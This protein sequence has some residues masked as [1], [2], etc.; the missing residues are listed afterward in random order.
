MKGGGQSVVP[1]NS[2]DL[3]SPSSTEVS[4]LSLVYSVLSPSGEEL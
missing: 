1:A 3:K 2:L 4:L